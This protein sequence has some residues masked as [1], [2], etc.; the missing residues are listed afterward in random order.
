MLPI[1]IQVSSL[2]VKIQDGLIEVE[3][4]KIFLSELETLDEYRLTA[5]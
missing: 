2:R 1:E 4:A 5:Q 3:A